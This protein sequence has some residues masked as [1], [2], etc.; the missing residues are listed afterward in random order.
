[1]WQPACLRGKSQGGDRGWRVRA[2]FARAM[3]PGRDT[4]PRDLAGARSA[5][6]TRLSSASLANKA[7][8]GKTGS[9]GCDGSRLCSLSQRLLLQLPL[10]ELDLLGQ[11]GVGI[12]EILDL[13]HGVQHR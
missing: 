13:P 9:A 4:Y 5:I 7:V 1:M 10:Q 6:R 8:G 11:C 3:M 12:D 2:V